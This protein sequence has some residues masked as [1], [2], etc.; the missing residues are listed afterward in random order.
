MNTVR[1]T[2]Y[3]GYCIQLDHLDD[4][5]WVELRGVRV[6]DACIDLD[7]AKRVVRA[8]IAGQPLPVC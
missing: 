3:R 8:H 6:T 1:T 7:H 2:K 4:R 5:M